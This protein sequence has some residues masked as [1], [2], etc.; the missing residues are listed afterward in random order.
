MK[1]HKLLAALKLSDLD[2][3]NKAIAMMSRYGKVRSLDMVTIDPRPDYELLVIFNQE[4]A[5]WA[6]ARSLG[7]VRFGPSGLKLVI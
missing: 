3:R 4:K 5:A 7:G 1:K 2:F 6:A